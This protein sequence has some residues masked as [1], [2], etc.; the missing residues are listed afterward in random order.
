MFRSILGSTLKSSS[1]HIAKRQ[2]P[3]RMVSSVPV[4]K[5]F[6]SHLHVYAAEQP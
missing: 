2:L 5:D 3:V 1:S 4:P 6:V